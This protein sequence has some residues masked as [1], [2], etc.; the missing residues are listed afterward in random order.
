MVSNKTMESIK[1]NW[2]QD[3]I[4]RSKERLLSVWN[5]KIPDD[6]SIISISDGQFPHIMYPKITH[7]KD[8]GSKMGKR[9]S[10]FL[11]ELLKKNEPPINTN[12]YISTKIVE[13]DSVK[14]L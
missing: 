13:L 4:E 6:I 1:K 10:S 7:L 5:K 9:A 14:A 11:L 8:S 2:P 3:R 12:I